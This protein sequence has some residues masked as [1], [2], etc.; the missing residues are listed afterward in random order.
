MEAPLEEQFKE[1]AALCQCGMRTV[2]A[3]IENLRQEMD[4]SGEYNPYDTIEWRIKDFGSV[5]E[6]LERKRKPLNIESIQNNVRDIAGIRITTL[7]KD[8]VY[9]IRD[10]LIR[11]PSLEVLEE[12]DYIAK[13]K[14]KGYQSLHLIVAMHVYFRKT[15]KSVPVEIQIRTK[16]I[17]TWA[18]IDHKLRYSYEKDSHGEIATDQ[19]IDK[20]FSKASDLLKEFD[21][22][23]VE[24]RRLKEIRK[25]QE[26]LQSQKP[27]Q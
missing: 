16:T 1:Y 10:A 15:T 6:K 24:I 20:L 17:D 4:F 12:R 8:D 25:Q 11:Q 19:E 9:K 27:P 7:F 26:L 2:L 13:P 21:D 14:K 22:T 23:I 5:E 18:S 3:R